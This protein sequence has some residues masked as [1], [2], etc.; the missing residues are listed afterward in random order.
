LVVDLLR[1][2]ESLPEVEKVDWHKRV[3]D[4]MNWNA[5]DFKSILK[6]LRGE[7]YGDADEFDQLQLAGRI[8]GNI[9]SENILADGVGVWSWQSHGVWRLVEE[10]ALKQ[11][12][13]RQLSSIVDQVN[14]NTVNSVADLIKN[15][16]YTGEHVWNRGNT[17]AVNCLNGELELSDDGWTLKPHCRENY[18]TVQV[19]VTY[20]PGAQCPR[21]EQFLGEV[22][23]GDPDAAQKTQAILEQMGYS[24]MRHCRYEFM[25]ML[26]GEGGNGK[27]V[28]MRLMEK[29]AGP[30]N[31]SGVQPDK[32]DSPFQRANLQNKL[33]N[34]IT[35]MEK[36]TVIADAAVKAITSGE[37][38]TVEHKFGDPF[39][40]APYSTLW[41]GTNHIPH[42]R[43][44]SHGLFRRMV[45]M[46]FNNTFDESL[47]NADPRLEEKLEAE[48]PGVLALCLD[49]Y[50]RAV[51]HGFT[52]PDST[53]ALRQKWR[54]DADQ[55]AQFVDEQCDTGVEYPMANLYDS[56][57]VWCQL[58]GIAKPLGKNH[59]GDRLDRLGYPSK[60]GT[61]GI[62]VRCG[63]TLRIGG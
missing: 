6:D 38:S 36:G 37:T 44:F 10:R 49:A 17:E 25:L 27:S 57:R 62:R 18:S 22:F 23:D 54:L 13:Q 58:S 24:L 11:L 46:S 12:V 34:I 50:A 45:V 8:I 1:L 40:M 42:T 48:L 15:E 7:W 3:R 59:F 32:F 60:R 19:P 55:V 56:Y 14:A 43:D 61:G 9:G 47:G 35:E 52:I 26:V 4:V 29:L 2:V 30:K 41:I 63:L 51:K 16:I 28:L 20:T 21:F 5:A 39:E 31:V 53:K 33:V